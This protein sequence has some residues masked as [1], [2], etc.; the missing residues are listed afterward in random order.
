VITV[1]VRREIL[2]FGFSFKKPDSQMD[3]MEA[4]LSLVSRNL[5]DDKRAE[6]MHFSFF[7]VRNESLMTHVNLY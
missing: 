1:S 5:R 7:I 4:I 3:K 2:N 6:S